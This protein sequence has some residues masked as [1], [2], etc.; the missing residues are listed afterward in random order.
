LYTAATFGIGPGIGNFIAGNVIERYNIRAIWSLNLILG[1]IGLILLFLA[2]W[3]FGG[4]AGV[5][6]YE[7]RKTVDY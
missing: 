7:S 5:I 2:L 1:M 3:Y 6:H 4:Q